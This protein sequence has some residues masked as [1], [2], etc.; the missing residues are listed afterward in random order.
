METGCIRHSDLPHT[1]RLFTDFVY[2]FDNVARFYA[3][4]PR[5]A[6][7]YPAAT[8]ALDYPDERRRAL[9]RVLAGQNPHSAELERLAQPGT[10]AVVTGQQV[11]LFSGPAYTIYKALTAVRLARQLSAQGIPAVPIF[12][13]ATED[14]D[15]AE[16]NHCWVFDAEQRPVLLQLP[17]NGAS[18]GPVGDI[19]P[20][21]VPIERLR[22]T[23]GA[24]PFAELVTDLTRK[25]YSVGRTMGEAFRELMRV[26][27]AQYGLLYFDPLAPEAR[28]LAAPLLSRAIEA[29]PDL[30]AAV[31]E[32]NRELAAAGYHAQV[33]VE[34]ETS[35]FFLL[36]RGRRLPLRVKNG[37]YISREQ[38]FS[39][40]EL[41][42][43]AGHLSP[44]ALLRPVVQDYLLPTAAYVGGPAELAYLAQAEVIYKVLLGRMPVVEPRSAFTLLD[45]RAA[46]LI[47][48]YRLALA[49]FFHGEEMLRERISHALVPVGLGQ[50]FHEAT[51]AVSR[52]LDNLDGELH[53]F[54]PTLATA[55]AKSRAKILYQLSKLDR[56]VSRE[57]LRRDARA[58]AEAAYL[59]HLIFPNKH[60]QER[61]YSILPFVARHGPD[62]ISRLYDRVHL[63]CPDHLLLTLE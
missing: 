16:V 61:F 11:G 28:A 45:V 51:G 32:R 4:P 12:W 36:E 5:D 29:A 55:L 9:V 50:H 63:D 40:E 6:K 39:P 20:L 44:N 49:D 33:H 38:R 62:M 15:F 27:L 37:N 2:H 56:K 52:I 23:M 41:S 10:V 34:P 26:L 17:P 47:E 48:R 18:Q 43:R 31:V 13:L 7:S 1:S 46:K 35:F 3:Y 54:D 42:A 30:H 21:G 8:A 57:A 60:L 53:A 19:V 14:H 59:Y 22:E 24:L 25:S 58:E